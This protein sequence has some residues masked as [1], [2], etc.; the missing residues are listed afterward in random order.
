MDTSAPKPVSQIILPTPT[1]R[2]ML[3]ITLVLLVLLTI[4]VIWEG[5]IIDF[6][7]HLIRDLSGFHFSDGK[8]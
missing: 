4:A 3:G 1:L 5:A 7:A 8:T 2:I 6:Q